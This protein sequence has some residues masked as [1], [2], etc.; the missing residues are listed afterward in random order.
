MRE[1]LR[2]N[3]AFYASRYR[4]RKIFRKIAAVM[5]CL[6]AFVTTYALILPAITLE[7][8]TFCGVEEHVHDAACYQ[9]QVE[10]TDLTCDIHVHDSTCYITPEQM[11][12]SHSDECIVNVKGDLLCTQKDSQGH[13]HID[14]CYQIT[15]ELLCTKVEGHKHT[16]ECYV[17]Q[18]ACTLSTEPHT[19][20]DS[21]YTNVLICSEEHEHRETCWQNTQSCGM[22][23]VVHQH[24]EECYSLRGQLVCDLE[25]EHTHDASCYFRELVC[26][27]PESEGHDHSDSCYQWE[28]K[29]ICGLEENQ[30][31][32]EVPQ[33]IC[34]KPETL[35]HVHDSSCFETE[36]VDVEPVCGQEHTH[37]YGCYPLLCAKTEHTHSLQCY[38]N[39]DAD[40]ES[41]STWEATMNQVKLTD[42]PYLNVIAIAESQLGYTESTQNYLVETDNSIC[43]YTRYGDWYGSPYGD[44]CAMFA[45]FCLRY[46]GV[47]TVPIEAHVGSWIE[48]L[49]EQGLY[50]NAAET[51]P[52]P[53]CLVFFDWETN[54]N[55]DHV[56]IVAEVKE[57]TGEATKIKTIEGNS[58][59]AVRYVEYDLEDPVIIG[60]GF[61]PEEKRD[62]LL[63]FLICGIPAHTH[64]DRCVDCQ[65]VEHIH[66]IDC[67]DPQSP[68]GEAGNTSLQ[69]MRFSLRSSGNIQYYSDITPMLENVVIE[70]KNGTVIYNSSSPTDS[71]DINI[72]EIYEVT[73]RFEE[74]TLEQ[75]KD[76]SLTYQIPEYLSSETVSEQT[77]I[78]YIYSRDHTMVATYTIVDNLLTV[79]PVNSFFADH[80]DSYFEIYFNAEAVIV[81]DFEHVEIDFGN[82]HKVNVN[83]KEDG[84]IKNKKELV[85]YDPLTR[86]LTYK[87]TTTAH[88]GRVQ[89]TLLYD[90]WWAEGLAGEH[91]TFSGV[92]LTDGNGTDISGAWN[93]SYLGWITPY[94]DYYLNHGESIVLTYQVKLSDDLTQNVNYQNTFGGYGKFGSEDVGHEVTIATPVT[95]TN[96]QKNGAYEAESVNGVQNALKWTV[97]IYNQDLEEITVTDQLQ[98]NQTYCTE[99][100]SLTIVA[101]K[102]DNTTDYITVPW[103]N[104]TLNAEHTSFTYTL[105]KGYVKYVL[106]Y[107]SHYVADE[108][109]PNIQTFYN[110]ITTKTD[111]NEIHTG[112]GSVDVLG[113]VP[114]VTKWMDGVDD[115]YFTFTVECFMPA[116]LN[117]K[118]SILL[119]DSLTS[120]GNEHG[121]IYNNPEDLTVTIAPEGRE[122]Y[123]LAP[124]IGQESADNTYLA[125]SDGAGFTMLFNT[126]QKVGGTSIWKCDVDSTLTISYKIPLNAP[127]LETWGGQPTGETLRHF[128]DRTEQKLTNEAKLDYLPGESVSD[129]V[130]YVPPLKSMA[131][132]TKTGEEIESEDGV[133][134]Y[135]VWFNPFEPESAENERFEDL[136]GYVNK[137]EGLTLTDTFDSQMEYVPGSLQISLWGF[138]EGGNKSVV[139]T[140]VPKDGSVPTLTS[141]GENQ[142]QMTILASDMF[143]VDS[144]QTEENSLLDAMRHHQTGYRYEINYQLRVKEEAKRTTEGI[145]F[146]DNSVSVDWTDSTGPRSIGPAE[147]QVTYNTGILDKS[148]HTNDENNLIDFEVFINHY[149]LNLAPNSETYILHDTMS[150]N[151]QLIYDSLVIELLDADEKV[152]G[153][154][155]LDQCNFSYEPD[156]NRMNFTLPDS[157][158]IRLKYQ[159]KVVA[160]GGRSVNVQNKVEIEGYSSIQDVVDT[161]FEVKDHHGEAGASSTFFTLQKQDAYTYQTLPY[162]SFKLYGDTDPVGDE[163]TIEANG[164]ILHYYGTFTTDTHGRVEIKHTQL[165]PGHKYALVEVAPPNGYLEQKEPYVFYMEYN[166]PEGIDNVA[167]GALVVI[168][169]YPYGYELPKTGGAGNY[170][171]V[172]AGLLLILT[173][174][175]YLMYKHRKRRRE[176][177]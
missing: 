100:K 65:V 61:Q 16:D 62:E 6:V 18:L 177:T 48:D 1:S 72:G 14:T 85:S 84:T 118:N 133:F 139:E 152:T 129:N 57:K 112:T 137:V 173:S 90:N 87:C 101:T 80:N 55:P 37:T 43:G 128:L 47:D 78:G 143:K 69:Q 92:T 120:W 27:I 59:D 158:I 94:N 135:T 29:Y 149:G 67:A 77:K 102:A 46:A 117:G 44:W 99:H 8:A 26:Q 63:E 146:L 38:S 115:D 5:G 95:F 121:F 70:D 151:L 49:T 124:Y 9:L 58:A 68:I 132:L 144:A 2:K 10:T 145:L 32:T 83:P 167:E 28:Q 136:G 162:V 171:Y 106:E 155:S 161:M 113:V 169:N 20:N 52:K 73:L 39:P 53:G 82:H 13:A 165:S 40:V 116:A 64:D 19:H 50:Y 160:A 51:Q 36:L 93:T 154:L 114:G 86:T 15:S 33:L 163:E 66:T 22:S 76:G 30:P 89:V 35:G 105:P 54:A 168:E 157:Q 138:W 91:V 41:Q 150:S 159:C 7:Q 71:I 12:H 42:D 17:P 11:L 25:E 126:N 31:V 170:L 108:N 75:F 175:A 21:C 156:R 107:R 147:H 103:E 176:V 96:V 142:T 140:F 110:S 104:V 127:M 88:G 123:Q 166:A 34:T 56:G 174:A 24:T 81:S 131:P 119:Y 141:L 45:S 172:G 134:E 109:D 79:T 122:P 153:T 148:M 60:Y 23:E 3:A 97:E 74:S 111:T 125:Y 130:E 98:G 164:T 4:A